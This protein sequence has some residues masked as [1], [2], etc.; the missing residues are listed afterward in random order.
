MV[1]AAETLPTAPKS[2]RRPKRGSIPRLRVSSEVYWRFGPLEQKILVALA[3][4]LSVRRLFTFRT[5]RLRNKTSTKG[6][7][8]VPF[9]IT[10]GFLKLIYSYTTGVLV[11]QSS[12]RRPGRETTRPGGRIRSGYTRLGPDNLVHESLIGHRPSA[13]RLVASFLLF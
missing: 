12:W 4:D 3:P 11:R 6:H 1:A 5:A 7:L 8:I 13:P 9:F 2:N 10:N